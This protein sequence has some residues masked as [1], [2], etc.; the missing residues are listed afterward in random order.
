MDGRKTIIVTGTSSGI[1][2]YCAHALKKDGW[3]VFATV[4][5]EEDRRALDADGIETFLMDY[6][7]HASIE[8]MVAAVLA[9]SGGRIDA[10]FNNGA[11]GQPGA[12]EDLP[13]EA[14]REQFEVNLFGWHHLTR[15]VIPHMRRTGAGR[16]VQCSSILG[17][18]PYRWRGAYTA[19]KFAL[20][21]LS[22]TLRMELDG[23]G[24]FVSLIEPGPIASRF[25]A[26]A[27][28]RIKDN[29]DLESSVHAAAYRRELARLD[30]TGPVNRYKLGPEAVY[31]VLI[32][33]LTSARPRPHYLVTT[34]AKRGY[35]LKKLMP[36]DLFYRLLRRFD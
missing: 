16:I 22:L 10:L 21:G 7:D 18:V 19:S 30:G 17:L 32:E 15:L 31:K 24:I 13:V 2:A 28:A 5:R 27:L 8:A 34:P 23:S 4:R 33:A 20:E 25:T 9:R 3:R 1:G 36:A 11:Y 26:N 12:V 14:L 35:F 29:I 6:R